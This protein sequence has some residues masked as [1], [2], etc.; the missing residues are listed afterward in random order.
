MGRWIPQKRFL[1][2]FSGRG[3]KQALPWKLHGVV[4]SPAWSRALVVTEHSTPETPASGGGGLHSA[5]VSPAVSADDVSVNPDV[6][7]IFGSELSGAQFTSSEAVLMVR[8]SF[9][10]R[11]PR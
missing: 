4:C 7:S 6:D 8:S 1:F 9:G 5:D 10:L 2:L 11:L 3:G